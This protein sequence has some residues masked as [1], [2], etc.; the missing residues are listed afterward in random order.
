MQPFEVLIPI[1]FFFSI[2]AVF[3]LR[4]PLGKALADRIAGR[5]VGGRSAAEGD[6]LW[7]EVVELRNR[8]EVLEELASRVQELEE[9]MDFA[10]R[11][12]AQQ[13]DRPRLGG[14]G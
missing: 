10:E 6:V 7:R 13:R 11:L 1:A 12:L 8:M 9:R 5:A 3:I 4:G 14:E 2:A